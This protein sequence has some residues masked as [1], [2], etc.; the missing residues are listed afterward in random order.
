[1][2]SVWLLELVPPTVVLELS[3]LM[4]KSF[5]IAEEQKYCPKGGL[6]R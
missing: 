4:V 6:P 3:P 1:M 5:P 2:V